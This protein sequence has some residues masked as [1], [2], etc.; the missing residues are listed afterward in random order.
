[1][2]TAQSRNAPCPCGSGKKFKRCC[3]SDSAG[4]TAAPDQLNQVIRH[5]QQG[6]LQAAGQLAE[7]LLRSNP[8]D[9]SLAEISAVIALQ[10]GR[11]E[12]AIER[13]EQQIALQPD[14]ALAHSNLCMALHSLGRDE[15]AYLSGQRAIKLDPQ[16]ADAWNNLGNI[17]KSGNHLLGAL[18]HYEKALQLDSSDPELH[19]NAGT[20]SQLLG[21]LDTAEQRYRDALKI[22]PTFAFAHNNLGA[23]MQQQERYGE[24][25]AE[26]RT[27]TKLQP[28]NPEFLTNLGSLMIDHGDA[29]MARKYLESAIKLDPDYAG[30]YVSL[31]NLYDR[32][33]DSDNTRKY[34]EKALLLDPENSTVH[35]N[36]AY[37]LHELG[38]QNEAV[39]HF[40]RALKSNPNSAK[41]LAGLGKAM[42]SEDKVEQAAEYIGKA[43]VL[44]PWDIH[45][46]IARAHLLASQRDRGASAAEWRYVIEHQPGMPDGYIGLGK[47][48]SDLGQYD[49]AR[50]Q[51]HLAELH[52]AAGLRLYQAWSQMEEHVHNLDE[53]ERL[54]KKAAEFDAS[55]SGLAILQSMLARR[56]KDHT[57]ALDILNQTDSAAIDNKHIKAS[58]LFERG[59]VLDKL[60]QYPEAFTAFEEANQ[61]KNSYAGRV[62]DPKKDEQKFTR[63]KAT[64]SAENW[65]RLSSL[66]VPADENSLQP[67]FIVGFPRSGTSLLEQILGSH[68]QI[69]PAGE[70]EFINDLS[71]DKGHEITG[72][73]LAYPAFL[74]DREAP[75]TQQHLLEMRDYYLS[76]IKTL[77]VVDSNTRWVTDK[78]PHNA[79]HAGLIKLL[80]PQSAVIHISRHPFNSCLSA[81]FSNFK[82]AH[83]YTSSFESTAL[84]YKQVMDMLLHYRSIGIEFLEIHYED[85]VAEQEAVTRRVL[86]YIGAPWSDACLQHHKS[87]RVVKTASYEQVTQKIYTSSLYR[88]RNYHE[89]VQRII[90]ILGPTIEQFGYTTD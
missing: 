74:L 11:P 53:A 69:A 2:H 7:Q 47:H 39:E 4:Y 3:G 31:G 60:G 22:S 67:V 80:F 19:V 42:L 33:N 8:G 77:G 50:A 78:M 72:S 61:A 73:K 66:M 46:H 86:D 87:V 54:A 81:F 38:D 44:A 36:M 32:L 41:G 34:Y 18:E 13:F 24:A 68:P 76:G 37:R 23:A 62:Y 79:V 51:F 75:L 17:Y 21:D 49:A 15:E 89:A 65:Q 12:L 6:N 30:A 82:P 64:F 5:Y 84:H 85:L 10:T 45:A 63:W 52:D 71:G 27:A 20:V 43:L 16:L 25:E 40:I 90:P 9:A 28:D 59:I 56:R 88:Y 55:Y 57:A 29:D 14:N 48:Y 35:C 83:R 1:M 70:L 58:Y 26:F